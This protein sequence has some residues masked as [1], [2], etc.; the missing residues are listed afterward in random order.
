MRHSFMVVALFDWILCGCVE[1]GEVLT[2]NRDGTPGATVNAASMV[3]VGHRHAC[4]ILNDTAYCWGDNTLGQLG[5]SEPGNH[6]IPRQLPAKI[7]FRQLVAAADHSCGLD[8]I[9]QIYCWGG[10]DRGQIG[11]G[12]RVSRTTPSLVTLP[13][14][15]THI[16]ANFYHTCALLLDGTLHC[17]GQNKEGE[18]GL[19]DQPPA[20]NDATQVDGLTPIQVTAERWR[21]VDTG[22][23]HTCAIRLDGTLWC[24]GRNSEHEL[25]DDPRIQVR[26]PIQVSDVGPWLSIAAGQHHS[27]GI[28]QDRSLWCWGLNTGSG[29]AE[30]FPLGIA[31]A[32]ELSAPTRVG[33]DA[34]WVGFGTKTFHSCGIRRA[35]ELFCWGRNTEGQLGMS[36]LAARPIPVQVGAEYA[37]IATGL[38][39]TCA[40]SRKGE[41]QC[42]GAN[43]HGE[44]GTGD[45]GRRSELT[46]IVLPNP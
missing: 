9:G 4:A 32:A 18:L 11:L 28:K 7:R 17:W 37:A 24:W 34:D 29:N 6:P 40:I 10:N 41:V 2:A 16:A 19:G 21:A 35:L 13:G 14:N 43:D 42:A 33:T 1:R 45:F 22:D 3:T 27:C 5:Y 31:D 30:G 38:F 23:G 36:D 44:L 39:S 26:A 46:P 8:D 25:G 15:A 20:D 12:D